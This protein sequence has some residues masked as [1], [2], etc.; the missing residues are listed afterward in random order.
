MVEF[1]GENLRLADRIA[2]MALMRFAKIAQAGTDSD[3]MD[4]LVAMYDLLEQ[5]VHPDDWPRFEALATKHRDQADELL[6]VIQSA[7]TAI[8]ARP[9]GPPSASSDGPA[10]ISGS[11]TGGSSS[12]VVSRLEREG[13]LSL[14]YLVREEERHKARAS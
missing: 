10:P 4:G 2:L 14:A 11:S 1:H 5:C 6:T 3:D 9:T 13:R 8:A 7:I 12:P